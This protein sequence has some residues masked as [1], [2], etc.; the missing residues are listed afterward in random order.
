MKQNP[1]KS[2]ESRLRHGNGVK[3]VDL[4]YHHIFQNL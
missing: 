3:E 4:P 1:L 2:A